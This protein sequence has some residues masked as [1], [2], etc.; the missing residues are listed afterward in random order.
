MIESVNPTLSYLIS[1]VNSIC[2]VD[3][4]KETRKRHYV[5]SRVLYYGLARKYTSYS[6]L[7]IGE[8]INR[9]HSTVVY[10]LKLLDINVIRNNDGLFSEKWI[11][12]NDIL[13]NLVADDSLLSKS[14]IRVQLQILSKENEKLRTTISKHQYENLHKEERELIDLYR[15]LP[16]EDK[17]FL[18]LK[19][20]ATLKM[21]ENDIR[22]TQE[23]RNSAKK[24]ELGFN[25]YL[26]DAK[27]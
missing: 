11:R 19:A 22:R 1:I 23:L 9:D 18:R 12:A 15:Q 20:E 13:Q 7:D 4:R 16:D 2:G 14:D 27:I 5:Y 10:H 24:R 21:I 8:S 17:R 25:S 3:I 26:S 6:T